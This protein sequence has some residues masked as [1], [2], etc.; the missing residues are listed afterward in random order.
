[1][2]RVLRPGGLA[3]VFEHNPYHPATQWV[4]RTTKI[5]QNAILLPPRE[6]RTGFCSVGLRD[7][8]KRYLLFFP[9]RWRWLQPVERWL[10]KLPLGGQYVIVAVK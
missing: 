1:M 6:V 10:E 5:D 9:P 4:V 2:A 7:I 3:V 8:Q